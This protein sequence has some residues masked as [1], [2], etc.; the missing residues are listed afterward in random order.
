[1]WFK[2]TVLH[3]F[4]PSCVFVFLGARPAIRTCHGGRACL[5]LSHT[6]LRFTPPAFFTTICCSSGSQFGRIC[7]YPQW[8]DLPSV[9]SRLQFCCF[10]RRRDAIAGPW[11]R[12]KC[13]Y[14][15]C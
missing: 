10:V 11:N 5:R 1:M 8:T 15:V 14:S 4:F 6:S 12:W 3:F 9:A 13:S 2:R 7:T